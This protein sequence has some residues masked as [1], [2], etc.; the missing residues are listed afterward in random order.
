M[1]SEH[2]P[3]VEMHTACA[4][5][6]EKR[7]MTRDV[8]RFGYSLLDEHGVGYV[9]A[10]HDDPALKRSLEKLGFW[11][12]N[13]VSTLNIKELEHG[14]SIGSHLWRTRNTGSGS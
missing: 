10:M 1:K 3:V 6:W 8:I 2:A 4:P 13:A 14:T 5:G 11:T 12:G 9:F 7:W